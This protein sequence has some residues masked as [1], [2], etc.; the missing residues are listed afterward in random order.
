M[1]E[2]SGKGM[3]V[4]SSQC[5]WNLRVCLSLAFAATIAIT[6]FLGLRKPVT[7]GCT[8]TYM[9]PTYIPVPAPPNATSNRYAL[10][11]YHEGWKKIDYQLHLVKLSGVPVLFIPGNGGSYKQ[12]RSIAAESDRAYNGGPLE[13]SFYQQS[14][15]TPLEA[16][17]EG[18]DLAD[19]LAGVTV[20][21]QYANHLDWF[22]VDLEGEHSAM[23]GWILEEHSEYVVQAVHRILDRYRSSLQMRSQHNDD[24]GE[25]LPTSVIL[26]G[27]S[28]GGFIAR[29]AVVHPKLRKGAVETVLTLSSPHRSPPMAVQPSFGRFFSQVNAAW[30][31]G[32]EAVKGPAW[33]KPPLA[34]VVVVSVTGGAHDYQVR[35]RMAS[36]DGIVPSTNGMTIGSAGMV[37]VFMSMEHQAILWCNEFV[38]KTAH[39]LLQLIDKDT[40]QPYP[41]SHTRLGVFVSNMRSALPQAFDLLPNSGNS[42]LSLPLPSSD[43]IG[44]RE[45]G[46]AG[47]EHDETQ[48]IT[49]FTCPQSVSWEGERADKDLH[50]ST[51]IMTILAMDGR[52]RWLDIKKLAVKGDWFVLV[53]NLAPCVGLRI[54]LWTEKGQQG[55]KGLSDQVIEVTMMM[56]QLPSGPTPPQIEPGGQTEQASPTGVLRLGP[57]DL[58]EFRYLT[59]SVTTHQPVSGMPPPSAVMAVGQ[60]FNPE[61]AT[62]SL[63][64]SWLL[65]SLYKQQHVWLWEYHPMVWNLSFALSLSS[66]PMVLDVKTSTCG[67]PQTALAKEHPEPED[68]LK[69]CKA[70]CFPPVALVWDPP[71]GLEVLPNLTTATVVVDSS[72]AIWGS[73]YGSEHTTI[74]LLAD[75]HCAYDVT[76]KVSLSAAAS[77][78]LLVHGLQLAG[79]SVAVV[80]FALMRQAREWELDNSLPSIVACIGANLRLPVPF[81][82]LAVGP[83][84]MYFSITVFSTETSP[85]LISFLGLSIICYIFANGAVAL[86]AYICSAVFYTGAFCHSFI[87]VR[88]AL[89]HNGMGRN[90]RGR[91]LLTVGIVASILIF[92]IHPSL[93]LIL[94]LLIHAWRCHCALLRYIL[95]KTMYL[96]ASIELHQQQKKLPRKKNENGFIKH[97]DNAFPQDELP[98]LA[99]PSALSF[100][101]TQLETFNHHQGV[102]LLH[103]ITTVMLIPSLVAFVQRVGLERTLPAFLDSV[104]AFGVVLHGIQSS[105]ADGNISLIRVPRLSGPPEP[106]AGLSFIYLLAGIYCYLNGLAQA[107]YRAFYALA[108]IG[109]ITAVIRIRDNQVRGK[110]EVGV[111]HRHFHRH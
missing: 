96:C 46:I 75:P 109:V 68:L 29:A 65:S 31:H 44:T 50:I 99:K 58:A 21:G 13:G 52:R 62:H 51:P 86:L 97:S 106:D 10:Y 5:W 111:K 82:A 39:T 66:V 34:N 2:G 24:K 47:S 16:G 102:L 11:L 67:I 95:E 12:M 56:V 93:G 27:H 15:F 81:F 103:L 74:V 25:I 48:K 23:D 57:K 9:Y 71:Y 26:V 72:Q 105:T 42:P 43:G 63:S 78:F 28:M 1:A 4:S 79:V 22:A 3:M 6:G 83:L 45:G 108:T 100:A 17:P 36:L 35:S 8:M 20:E 61:E 104:L 49:R 19:V 69:M 70:R 87:K 101:E 94:L 73:S 90:L 98:S 7:N 37:N 38:V 60:F 110:G 30:V 32:Y 89:W 14:S 41:S 91:P 40:G 76:F 59:V 107:P 64:A 55:D 84:L 77:R 53:T 92:V 33:T 80:L 88:Y 85:S 18:L 54:H